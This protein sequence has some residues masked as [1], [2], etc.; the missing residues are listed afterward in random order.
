MEDKTTEIFRNAP[1][2]KAVISNVI[3]S[4]ISMIM[5][6]LY[7]LADTFFIGQTK[8]AYM[9]AAVS[10]A[11][12]AFLFFMAVGMLFGIGGTS[13]ISRMLG[14][15]NDKKAKNTS[16]F[17]FWTGLIIGVVS[18][19]LIWMFIR[20]V[21]QM[22]GASDDTI[23]Y[24]SEY[25]NIVA[26]GIPFLIISNS[27]S[28]IIRAEGNAKTAMAGMIFGNVINIVLDPVLI[29]GLHWNVAGAA[30]A[31]TLSNMI[32]ALFYL[33]HLLS[34][35]TMLSV[36]LS[37]YCIKGGIAAGVFAIGVP[38]SLNSILLSTSNIIVNNMMAGYGDMAVA[39]LGVAM[40]VNLI[41]VMLLIGLGTG[42]QP[43]LGYCFG[44]GNGKRY[45]E[46][47]RFSLILAFGMS[48]IMTVI[49]YFGAGPLVTAFLDNA[50][51]F[52]FG[53]SFARIYIFSGPII[54]ILFVFV[55]AIQATGAALPA[56]ILSV[57]RQGILYIPIL[58]AFHN[59]LH[60]AQTLALA[61]PVADYLSVVLAAALF[62]VTYRK[63]IK[64][65]VL[66]S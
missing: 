47:L 4:I 33:R 10:V 13:L 50:D 12:P 18:M 51:A 49:C 37:D 34:K 32:S 42:I 58:L 66:T 3:P 45:M 57:S 23:G 25:L 7:N 63:Y 43:L 16:A 2:P 9:V 24:A 61:Q 52:G 56:L 17:C 11:T 40:K 36:R 14:E 26:A 39:G 62:F 35:K 6:L 28:N 30:I 55:N 31:T 54:G 46:V 21:C 44:A 5:V 20:P 15:G 1:V 19:V 59:L 27:F 38:A 60:T 64:K 65:F 48:V 41:V 53:M 22:V 29:L 8:D